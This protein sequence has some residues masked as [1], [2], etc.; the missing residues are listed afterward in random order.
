MACDTKS[1]PWHR[2]E[3]DKGILCRGNNMGKAME[4]HGLIRE[5]GGERARDIG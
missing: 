3:K 4:E 5:Q 1:R 2:Q